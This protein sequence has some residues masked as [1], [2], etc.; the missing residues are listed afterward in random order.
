MGLRVA[1]L[2]NIRKAEVEPVAREVRALVERVADVVVYDLYQEEDLTNVSADVAIVLGGDGAILRSAHQMGTNQIPV[3]GVNLGKLG[4][5]AEFSPQEFP[6]VFEQLLEGAYSVVEHLMLSCEL[7]RG[8]RTLCR[9]LS[10]N[11]VIIQSGPP[12]RMIEIA[13]SIDGEHV[14]TFAGDGLIVATPVGSTAHSLAAGGPILR[15]DIAAVVI[16]PL[17]P[18]TLTARPLV[19]GANRLYELTVLPSVLP[20]TAYLVVDGIEFGQVGPE[21]RVE[22]RQAPV[23]FKLV[24]LR[25]SSYYRRLRDKLGWGDDPRKENAPR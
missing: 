22:V 11:E 7:R 8:E 13:L 17:C 20:S 14:A 15:Q 23:R 16:T 18:H 3:V 5:L 25:G 4:F 21:D 12:F 6:R 1:I 19:D 2:G 24:Q 9:S 10:L